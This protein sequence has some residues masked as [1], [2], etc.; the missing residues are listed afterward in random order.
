MWSTP[1]APNP[2]PASLDVNT[3]EETQRR[4]EPA[5][6]K[7][8]VALCRHSL[9]KR[10]SPAC[11]QDPWDL[12]GPRVRAAPRKAPVSLLRASL[13]PNLVQVP[14]V[15]ISELPTSHSQRPPASQPE[16][17]WP[18]LLRPNSGSPMALRL[19]PEISHLS[20]SL[21]PTEGYTTG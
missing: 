8:K 21:F 12:L 14:F 7:P 13:P 11:R 5:V 16:A 4:L 9:G 17:W 10:S 20:D 6:Y 3:N 2:G 18:D 19:N 1:S 15:G